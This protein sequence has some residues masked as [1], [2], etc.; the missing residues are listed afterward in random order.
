LA[1][2]S[3]THA[4]GKFPK[5]LELTPEETQAAWSALLAVAEQYNEPGKFTAFIGYEW[6][7]MPQSRSMHRVVILK[8]GAD[9]AGQT[10]PF[11]AN[12]S[13]DPEKLWE[14]LEQYEQQSGGSAIAIPHSA[15]FS[16][17]QMFALER[18]DKRPFDK[19]YAERRQRFE[20]LYEVTQLKGSSEAHPLLS[21]DDRFADFEIQDRGNLDLSEPTKPEQL[22]GDY[23]REAYKAGVKLAMDL[24]VNPFKF[25]LVGS[26]D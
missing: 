4:A 3:R 19:A 2:L 10:L 20:P 7:S 17:G 13:D 12:Q 14:A 6:T 22:S 1:D 16:N 23:A 24:G 5:E 26:T 8:D 21:P 9:K 15:N 11:S 18:G 25:G